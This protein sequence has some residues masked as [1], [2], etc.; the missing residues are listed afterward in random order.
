[1]TMREKPATREELVALTREWLR[2]WVPSE[3]T[4]DG[5]IFPSRIG[6]DLFARSSAEIQSSGTVVEFSE[7]ELATEPPIRE[8]RS[9]RKN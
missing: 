6:D 1:M 8:K 9:L 3:T 4:I 7:E 5:G 2:T